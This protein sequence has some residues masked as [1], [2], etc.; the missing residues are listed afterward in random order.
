MQADPYLI[1]PGKE[2]IMLVNAARLDTNPISCIVEEMF[3]EVG[4]GFVHGPSSAGK[5]YAFVTNLALA[6]ANGVP[7]FGHAT[8]Q[9]P[10]VIALGEGLQDAG[11]RIKAQLAHHHET[12]AARYQEILDAG[13][14]DAAD[15]F[16]TEQPAYTDHALIVETE[17]FAMPFEN[18][19]AS[20]GMQQFIAG[21]GDL[22]PSLVIYDAM[23]DFANG[24]SIAHESGANK[25]IDG[26]K[27]L[28]TELNCFVLGI[29]HDNQD[30]K[31][32][33]GNIRFFN[34]ADVMLGIKRQGS[35]S[36]V[37]SVIFEKVKYGSLGP[38][39]AYA[40]QEKTWDEPET[41]ADGFP[42]GKLVPVKTHVVVLQ[43]ENA[44]GPALIRP[45]A[46]QSTFAPAM[47]PALR[48]VKAPASKRNGIKPPSGLS[49]EER[50]ARVEKLLAK[51]CHECG[52]PEGRGCN[53]LPN[54]V[55]STVAPSTEVHV[56]R[57]RQ[58][59]LAGVTA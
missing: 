10:V 32:M 28:V 31:K 8:K 49:L 39:F 23:A 59:E 41:D 26:I 50:A 7:F 6:V 21:L 55:R 30:G 52:A 25:Y 17:S 42:T 1:G 58:P 22:A 20:V 11:I 48:D 9:G 29:A 40:A 14:Q 16:A 34:A 5:S 2:T 24:A 19:K 18:G 57:A 13:G 56:S 53:P 4:S 36:D 33:A 44:D 35:D 51:P 43:D 45:E 3:P 27:H 38:A 37:S 47:L 15:A 54:S 46:V 12:V